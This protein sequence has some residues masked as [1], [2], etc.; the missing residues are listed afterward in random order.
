MLDKFDKAVSS[1]SKYQQGD[2]KSVKHVVVK[3]MGKTIEKTLGL[4]NSLIKDG[5]KVDVRTGS[6]EVVDEF[7]VEDDT[8]F[9]KRMVS[10]VE[11]QIWVKRE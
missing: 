6:V 9:Q 4:G 2:Y 8:L 7:E 1:S 11:L 5:Y 10:Y 3:G